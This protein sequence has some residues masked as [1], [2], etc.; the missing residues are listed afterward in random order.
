MP[1]HTVERGECFSS[2]ARQYGFADYHTLYDHPQNAPLKKRRPNPNMLLPGDEVFIPEHE[3]KN[4][5]IPT[6]QPKKFVVKVAEAKLRVVVKDDQ[7]KPAASKKYKLSGQIAK[8]GTT[9][10]SGQIE[11]DIPPDLDSLELQVWVKPDPEPPRT[12]R[13]LVGQLGPVEEVQGVQ[14]R[15]ANLGLY[16]GKIDGNAKSIE[17]ALLF[18]QKQNKLKESGEIDDATRKKLTEVHDG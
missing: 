2:I 8:E 18:F 7:E 3:V 16:R 6:D 1:S 10:G 17:R 4:V 11:I 14:A 5:D 13:L 12:F 9:D 15:L